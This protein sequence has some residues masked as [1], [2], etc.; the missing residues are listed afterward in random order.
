MGRYSTEKKIQF[1]S[2]KKKLI[3]LLLELDEQI[4]FK[5]SARGWCYLLENK[6]YIDKGEFDQTTKIINDCRD[7]GLL[8]VDFTASD[9]SRDFDLLEP[10]ILNTTKPEEYLID[11]LKQIKYLNQLKEDVSF[12]DKQEYYLMMLVEKI[13]IKTLFTP[14]CRKYHISIGNGKGWS[15]KNQRLKIVQQCYH[16]EELGLKPVIL[17]YGDFD[18]GGFKISDTLRKNIYDIEETSKI[19]IKNL[20]TNRIG[21]NLDYIE[22]YN[23]TWIDNLISASGNK[24]DLNNLYVKKYI[25]LN[26][27]RKCEANAI[28]PN[29]QPAINECEQV[30][31]EYLGNNCLKKHNERL[32]KTQ[33]ETREL[34]KKVDLKKTIQSLINDIKEI[35]S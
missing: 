14:I 18:I 3:K 20:E 2:N 1:E 27:Y 22:K 23:L 4:S 30:I 24:P 29:P 5:V 13:D 17:Y 25:E 9:E 28:L 32:R 31:L 16:A 35:K 7:E 34:M 21:L 10:L 19:Y 12:W 26:G 33:K 6:N 11:Y 8:P 15:S